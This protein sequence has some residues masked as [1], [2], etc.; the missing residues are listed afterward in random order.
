MNT[1]SK[2]VFRAYTALAVILAVSLAAC[3]TGK[4]SSDAM[5]RVNGREIP[6]AEVEKYYANQTANNPQPVSDEQA[7]ILRLSILQELIDNELL[8]QR[9]EKLGLLATDEEVDRELTQIKA[10]YTEEEFN[11]R[12]KDRHIT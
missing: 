5:A 7:A 9:A 1:S 11:Q 3:S 8:M 12:L 2:S 6:R 10:P 4:G